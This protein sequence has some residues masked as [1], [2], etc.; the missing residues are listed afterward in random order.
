M[1]APKSKSI[2]VILAILLMLVAGFTIASI[3]GMTG[4]PHFRIFPVDTPLNNNLLLIAEQYPT[5]GTYLVLP[6]EEQSA[7]Y[8]VTQDIYYLGRRVAVGDPEE[9]SY[10]IGLMFEIY[11]MA[12]SRVRGKG[13]HLPRVSSA[14]FS[15]FRRDWYGVDGNSRTF[16][17][18]L[19]DRRLGKEIT[20]FSEARPGDL[21]QFWRI[22][23]S[24]HSVL[25]LGWK[26]DESHNIIGVH[27]W[28]VQSANGISENVE[29]FV[30]AGGGILKDRIFIVRAYVP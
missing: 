29:Y 17:R 10:C 6:Q 26:F 19:V 12:C 23:G 30:E 20:I 25:F 13:F 22:G 8:G 15:A 14:N 1:L 28:S 3:L 27:Y 7:S 4:F 16:V 21:M 24:G 11:M 5:D 9:R 18:T 2:K